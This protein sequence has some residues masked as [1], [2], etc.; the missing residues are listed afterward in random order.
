D[1]GNTASGDGCSVSCQMEPGWLCQGVPSTCSTV[2]GDGLVASVEGCDDGNTASLDGCSA[3]CLVEV[4]WTC[5]GVPSSCSSVCGDSLVAAGAES[6]DDGNLRSRDGC[7]SGCTV[8]SFE[9]A[10]QSPANAPSPRWRHAM[11][12]DAARGVTV[13][14]G[15]DAAT[16]SD[17]TWE[18]DGT[19]WVETTPATSPAGRSSHG[20]NYDD[21]LGVMVMFGGAISGFMSDE[22]WEFDGSSWVEITF[23]ATPLGRMRH[24]QAYDEWRGVTTIFGGWRSSSN[25][26]N[27]TWEYDG[28]SWIDVSPATSPSS[29][30]GVAMAFDSTRGVTV[31]FGGNECPNGSCY[32]NDTWEYDGTTWVEIGTATAPSPREHH[33][34]VYDAL[35]RWVVLFGGDS[36]TG[37]SNE[38]WTYGFQPTWADEICGNGTDDDADGEVDCDD[39][40]CNAWL[41][42]LPLE[43][44]DDGTDD[45]GDGLVDCADPNCG[46]QV[47]DPG[48]LVCTAGMCA[49]PGGTVETLCFDGLDNDCDGQSDCAG[50]CEDPEITCD[51]NQDNDQDNSTD[52]A[53]PDCA[54]VGYC[55]SPE[56]T[57]DDGQDN[58]GD[59]MTDCFDADCN[60]DPACAGSC[61]WPWVRLSEVSGGS[62]DFIEIVNNGS[63]QWD[64]GGL[65]VTFRAD[66][67]SGIE[68]F[69]VPAGT[70][71]GPG[72]YLRLVD[73]TIGLLPDELYLG[74]N[75]CQ[76]PDQEMWVALCNGPCDLTGCTNFLDYFEQQGFTPPVDRPAC[77]SFTPAPLNVIAGNSLNSATRVTFNGGGTAGLQSD[78]TLAPVSRP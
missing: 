41:D 56:V 39:P 47:C 24:A 29:R 73:V 40:D 9:W 37:E 76:N 63:C 66:C 7:S 57:C 18:Y 74:F 27:D 38:T 25:Y 16:V 58:D 30:R 67:A 17:D 35:R 28:V 52:C 55:E 26:L 3:A 23:S 15:G 1:D 44:C 8:E 51:D 77:A 14:F 53:D 72:E 75:L 43:V 22:T 34:M 64:M 45:D 54:G 21:G 33:A 48:G 68:S 59:G 31:L 13:L 19:N 20:L 71:V 10:L 78:W 50:L 12:Y 11:A 5:L 36:G 4:G 6:C 62:P 70:I 42:C 69:G 49:C 61:G 32:V 60:G 65:T 2:C 46:G